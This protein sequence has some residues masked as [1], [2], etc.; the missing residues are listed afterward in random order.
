MWRDA[1]LSANTSSAEVTSPNPETVCGKSL[2]LRVLWAH[3]ISFLAWVLTVCMREKS[4]FLLVVPT[5]VLSERPNFL[6]CS[7]TLSWSLLKK[8]YFSYLILPISFVFR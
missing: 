7:P 4:A 2:A 5:N 1:L 6:L 8:G 3:F